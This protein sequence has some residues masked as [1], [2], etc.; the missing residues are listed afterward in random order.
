MRIL[1]GPADQS[2][3]LDRR[4]AEIGL[5]QED[6][7]AARNSGRNRSADKRALLRV[8]AEEAKAKGRK[9]P[10]RLS[11]DFDESLPDDM[12]DAFEGKA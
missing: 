9:L 10:F 11:E 8:L 1:R 6:F 12:L 2:K 3:F 7:D 5:M 4:K